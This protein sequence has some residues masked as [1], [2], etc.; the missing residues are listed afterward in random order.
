MEKSIKIQIIKS[1]SN[2]A[3]VT[4]T[5]TTVRLEQNGLVLENIDYEKVRS[6]MIE[7]KHIID[8]Y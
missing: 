7:L 8:G 1:D 4:P 5:E 6:K 2:S 3:L